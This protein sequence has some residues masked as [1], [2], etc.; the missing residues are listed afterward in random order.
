M[1][2][3]SA[4]ELADMKLPELPETKMG[5]L[6]RSSVE[7]W[8]SRSR[9]G[10][11]GGYEFSVEALPEKAR[12]E[13]ARRAAIK[14]A[15]NG[16]KLAG[17]YLQATKHD[18]EQKLTDA[19]ALSDGDREVA[20]KRLSVIRLFRDYKTLSGLS[21]NKA[22]SKFI[23]D[24][25]AGF[26]EISVDKISVPT[27]KRWVLDYERKGL[28]GLAPN[29]KSCG[30]KKLIDEDQEIK[31]FVMGVLT[32]K[33]HIS[34]KMMMRAIR[35]SFSSTRHPSY[36]TVCRYI[37]EWKE[38]NAALFT[39]ITNPDA[40]KDKYMVA[41]G[42]RSEHVTGLNQLWEFDSTPVDVL[43]DGDDNTRRYN[44]I[45]CLDV[46]SRRAKMYISRSSTAVG[47]AAVFRKALLDWG[48][49]QAIKTDNGAD[50]VS[51]HVTQIVEALE[52][53]QQL[54][55]PYSPE[56]KPHV[57][58]F[59]RTFQHGVVE[60]LPGYCGHN[61][62]ERQALESV[63]AFSSRLGEDV[64]KPSVTP[65]EF[66]AFADEWLKNDYEHQVHSALKMSPY[67]K[68]LSWHGDIRSIRDERAL[69]M[70]LEPVVDIRVV[71]K[72]GIMFD[73]GVYS[74]PV[75]ATLIGDP[76]QLKL[77]PMDLG[78]VYVYSLE[79]DFICVAVDPTRKGV[80]RRAA[81]LEAKRLQ[82]QKLAD[83]KKEMREFKRQ[84]NPSDIAATIM[85]DAARTA[86]N[87]VA[88]DRKA[89]DYSTDALSEAGKAAKAQDPIE[90]DSHEHGEMMRRA[91]KVLDA[92][93]E[94]EVVQLPDRFEQN[95][96]R[97]YALIKQEEA[98]I[99]LE[100][101]D[102]DFLTQFRKSAKFQARYNF[103]KE[104][105]Q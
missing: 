4:Q 28:A 62:V 76:V 43:L 64:I 65:E 80:D 99:P 63:K 35:A 101:D 86:E 8:V 58:R 40:Y 46:W 19:N 26:V 104:T 38:K 57:E 51:K 6:K 60:L 54:C 27:L 1:S 31:A 3:F 77:D 81:A 37:N 71:S 70:L 53:D 32:D 74:A 59:F 10:R 61:V 82:K 9:Q 7:G 56:Q 16:Q 33:P 20:E 83:Q 22:A 78:Q 96:Q 50:Y 75:L 45:S 39:A 5:V 73:K 94:A 21:K 42:S 15:R 85:A 41:H 93:R 90:L 88:F 34:N 55:T 68:A 2:Y 69:D 95:Y 79:N 89:S 97:A 100:Q 23:A 98:G 48:V 24:V 66:Q 12:I 11:G 52:V 91:E 36:A 30:R 87:V 102:L 14:E 92:H 72:K 29:Y 25:K 84:Q 13:I 18:V 49:P 44:I 103:E 47:V 67:E 17:R 105:V